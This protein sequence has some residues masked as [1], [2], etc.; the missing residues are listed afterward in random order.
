M[1]R[2]P[3]SSDQPRLVT[4]P[5]TPSLPESHSGD[6]DADPEQHRSSGD[7][8]G[9]IHCDRTFVPRMMTAVRIVR[10]RVHYPL[11]NIKRRGPAPKRLC[12]VV[13]LGPEI[14]G[15]V[16]ALARADYRHVNVTIEPLVEHRRGAAIWNGH[17][18][19]RQ[20][21]CRRS[22]PLASL[23]PRRLVAQ[24]RVGMIFWCVQVIVHHAYFP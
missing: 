18:A 24:L 3:M 8:C 5:R 7:K 11:V 1:N 17:L 13:D 10:E 19:V 15:V 6:D 20:A 2:G 22:F 4:K 21:V 12:F 9:R 23:R 16:P 14:H